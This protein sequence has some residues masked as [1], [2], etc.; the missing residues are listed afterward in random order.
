MPNFPQIQN[1]LLVEAGNWQTRTSTVTSSP[2]NANTGD[3]WVINTGT[4]GQTLNLPPVAQG[5][6]VTVINVH[7]TGTIIVSPNPA[8]TAP[9]LINGGS[10]Y[11]VPSGG[12]GAAATKATFY[13]DGAN[14][15]AT[16]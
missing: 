2:T 8:D 9:P 12:T 5:G 14:W 1:S 7:A 15:F 11:T 3:V 10:S 4:A 13:S 6:P 16:G